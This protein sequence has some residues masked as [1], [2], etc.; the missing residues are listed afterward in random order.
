MSKGLFTEFVFQAV[1]LFRPGADLTSYL[2]YLRKSTALKTT[3]KEQKSPVH[4][5]HYCT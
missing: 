4:T 2:C 5:R 1:L 3:V